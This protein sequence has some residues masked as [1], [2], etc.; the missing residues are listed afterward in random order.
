MTIT[1]YRAS[2]TERQLQEAIR[3]AAG[4]TGWKCFHVY[5]S[6]RSVPGFPDLVLLRGDRALVYELKT[7]T[8]RVR[9]EQRDWLE[10]FNTAGIPARIVRPCDL[11]AVLDEL[12]E[13]R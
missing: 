12:G 2:M 10:A 7:E 4:R 9:P 1:A 6:R 13:A 5:D 8:G 11:D 3:D